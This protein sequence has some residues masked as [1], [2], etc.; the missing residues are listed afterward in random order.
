VEQIQT[1]AR[2]RLTQDEL[3]EN[4]T[5]QYGAA[6]QRLATIYEFDAEK[7]TDLLQDIHLAL[8][9]SFERFNGR[10]SVR[11]WVYRIAHNT[12]ASHAVKQRRFKQPGLLSLEEAETAQDRGEVERTADNA[13]ALDRL[14]QLIRGLRPVDRQVILCYLEEMDAISIA[15]ITG[16]T[17]ANIATKIH[18]IKNILTRRFFKEG[19][20]NAERL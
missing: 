10:C 15:E 2:K 14:R 11:T 6:L 19:S 9:Q 16:L 7:R 5:R 3:Y 18:R 12:A 8:W 17:P 1:A 20:N 13:K 4:A